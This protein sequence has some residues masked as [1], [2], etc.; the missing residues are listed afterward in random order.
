MVDISEFFGRPLMW[1]GFRVEHPGLAERL[2]LLQK[3]MN[4]IFIREG[5]PSVAAD[6]LLFFMGRKCCEE[7]FEIVLLAA[8]GYGV[9]TMKL[10]R[11]LFENAI[12][13]AYLASHPD[14]VE[15]FLDFHGI[16]MKRMYDALKTVVGVEM[17]E[18]A[19][20][21]EDVRETEEEYE[22]VKPMFRMTYCDKCK[23]KRLQPSWTKLSVE[24]M[25]E[26]VG[27]SYKSMYFESYFKPMMQTHTTAM[28]IMQQIHT[29]DGKL[30]V[31]YEW[32]KKLLDDALFGA[33]RLIVEILFTQND[34]FKLELD[35]EL[36][37]RQQDF[38]DSWPD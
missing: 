9:G 12:T 19:I 30:T 32:T 34:H 24:Q 17:F 7:F 37:Q 36:I 23:R 11:S 4:K 3:T 16:H 25:L 26:A 35:E 33:H 18:A 38:L 22:R 1:A 6:T 28:S 2:G 14:E 27:G 29:V 10:L 21:A 8:N 15:K 5:Y 20:S 13:A 31:N